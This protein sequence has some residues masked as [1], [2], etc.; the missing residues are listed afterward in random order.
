MSQ[1]WV[2]GPICGVDN[3][4]SRLY[5]SADGLKICQY[6]HVME[7]NI[8]INDDQDDNYIQTKRLNINLT[9]LGGDFSNSQTQ[10]ANILGGTN[11]NKKLYGK[12]AKELYLQCIQILLQKQLKIVIKLCLESVE[13]DIESEIE[14]LVKLYWLRTLK[15]YL[16]PDTNNNS[17]NNTTKNKNKNHG[18]GDGHGVSPGIN[19]GATAEKG[20]RPDLQLNDPN[21]S[22]PTTIDLI[23]I[24]Y[25]SV[26]QLKLPIYAHDLLYSIKQNDIPYM[27]CFHLIP[28]S[29]L[30]RL[31]PYYMG[32]LEPKKLPLENELYENIQIIGKRVKFQKVQLSANY[33]YPLI[34]KILSKVL[35]FPNAPDLFILWTKLCAKIVRDDDE[36]EELGFTV[37]DKDLKNLSIPKRLWKSKGIPKRCIVQFPELKMISLIITTIKFYFMFNPTKNSK[38]VFDVS[39]WLQNI[40]QYELDHEFPISQTNNAEEDILGWSD[41]K[42]NRYCQW[43]YEN[44]IPKKNKTFN[45]ES[46]NENADHRGAEL[47][48]LPMMDKRLFQIFNIDQQEYKSS[49]KRKLDLEK[50]SV[51]DNNSLD[52]AVV[53]TGYGSEPTNASSSSSSSSSSN[54]SSNVVHNMILVEKYLMEKLCNECGVTPDILEGCNNWVEGKLKASIDVGR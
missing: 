17:I 33:Y 30:D 11:K 49:G 40:T 45:I 48:E 7:G 25:L 53:F 16:M 13:F 22:L 24:I 1:S 51:V 27:K 41:M 32:L 20:H 28:K 21:S 38:T 52:E 50:T 35:F 9:G 36:A 18:A 8:E 4:T 39:T 26:L 12:A 44:L 14:P 23:C 37:L 54:T 42:I 3:C 43:V 31:P 15:S 29:L 10:R 19:D 46:N 6:G 5:R 47:E 2:R 34:L